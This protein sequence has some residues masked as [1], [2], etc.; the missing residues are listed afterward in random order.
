MRRRGEVA[1]SDVE[2]AA[3]RHGPGRTQRL[4]VPAAFSVIYDFLSLHTIFILAV[5]VLVPLLT[6]AYT[7]A[8]GEKWREATSK[9]LLDAMD[10]AE[11]NVFWSLWERYAFP[12][13]SKLLQP[14]I[15]MC[16]FNIST[17][18]VQHL[19][20]SRPRYAPVTT[21]QAL[22][23]ALNQGERVSSGP[24]GN[25]MPMLVTIV[26]MRFYQQ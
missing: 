25:G 7:C 12:P 15:Y 17:G 23:D 5:Y 19:Y 13:Y 2:G 10:Q 11:R 4:L 9:A 1:G 3:G 8:G 16:D 18:H 21:S 22:L 20:Q 6:M 26:I 24:P 14:S